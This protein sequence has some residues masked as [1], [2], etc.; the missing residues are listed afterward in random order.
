MS[1]L[2]NLG[3]EQQRNLAV[4]VSSAGERAI[5]SGHP[6]I[7][8]GAIESVSYDAPSGTL[9]VIFDRRRRF[10]A[11]GLYD[12]ASP[13]RIRIL[14]QGSS[15][16]IDQAWLE[17]K[18]AAAAEKRLPLIH[19]DP[20]RPTD[21]FRLVYGENDGLPGLILDRYADTNVLKLY[22]PAWIPHLPA[23]LP[24]LTQTENGPLATLGPTR[25]LVL[26]LNRSTQNQVDLLNGLSDGQILFGPPLAGPVIFQENGLFFEAEPVEGQK[27]GF[28]LDQRENRAK[29]EELVAQGAG[30]RDVLNV[31]AYTGGFSLYAARGGA[32]R[33]LSLDISAPALAAAERNFALNRADPAVAAA[34]HE[35]LA[36]DAFAALDQMA[37]ASRRFD[38]VIVDPPA[39]A[40]RQDEVERA[41]GAYTKLAH[42][43]LG[44]LRPGGTLVMAS[45]SSRVSA[46]DFFAAI[47][48]A[49][50]SA[51]RPLQEIARTGHPVDHPVGF[52]EGAYLKCL[53][54]VAS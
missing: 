17:A 43:A 28:F 4:R 12:P 46:D 8:D 51:H 31:F 44:V 19:G 14:H 25:R 7:F 20:A 34:R 40:K 27:T 45:C 11:V 29:V 41:F 54:G 49:A 39:F 52:A 47:H 30:R 9:A 42:L 38:M 1:N 36:A 24:G 16:T 10:L 15:A 21:G 2:S 18:L 5:R 35:I 6:W 37:G 3:S 23:L 22:T 53:Y 48:A 26:R 13:I 50:Q 32:S 33:V